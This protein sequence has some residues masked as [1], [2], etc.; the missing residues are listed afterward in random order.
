MFSMGFTREDMG[1]EGSDSLEVALGCTS[2]SPCWMRRG[3]GDAGP[4]ALRKSEE[5]GSRIK[6]L[7]GRLCQG[8]FEVGDCAAANGAEENK[9][10]TIQ[11]KD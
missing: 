9:A 10:H 8:V 5:P 11:T 2:G 7:A 4:G 3:K 1:V 6:P